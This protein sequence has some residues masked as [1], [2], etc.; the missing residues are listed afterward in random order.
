M[1]FIP[2]IVVL[3]LATVLPVAGQQKVQLPAADR[4][5]SLSVQPLYTVG[6]AEGEAW[7]S[8]A[9]VWQVAF[10]AQGR[11]YVLDSGNHRIHVFDGGG[12][13]MRSI[14]RR[15][16]G[17]GEFH[18]PIGLAITGA[19]ELVVNDAMRALQ[20]FSLN[21]TYKRSIEPSEKAG[22][23]TSQLYPHGTDGVFGETAPGLGSGMR[24]EG[25]PP[26][27]QPRT[28]AYLPFASE[29]RTL[30][31][32]PPAQSTEQR[33]STGPEQGFFA[34]VPVA[35]GPRLNWTVLPDRRGI[36]AASG[37]EYRITVVGDRGVQTRVIERAI[38]PRKVT[39]SDR[40]DHIKAAG[41][42]DAIVIT[43]PDAPAG[44]AE[45]ARQMQK[46]RLANM[47]FAEVMPVIQKLAADPTG[48]VW[49]QRSGNR[50]AGGG[51]IDLISPQ[52]NY[53]GTLTGQKMPSAFGPD[54]RVAYIEKDELG[55][56]RVVVKRIR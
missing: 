21:G 47:R 29:P 41:N 12:K 8:F 22:R 17:P 20:V 5:A 46:E 49:V 9:Q 56:Q 55:V 30:Y 43:Q 39:Q 52:G 19:D 54:G 16:S 38:S 28:I 2:L 36:A 45:L 6:V 33:T 34:H 32:A 51:P 23:V 48:R 15:G 7:E 25:A 42:M 4:A 40:E 11:L 53:L 14:G 1:R 35:F 18:M 26:P 31:V 27:V 3:L 10:D 50:T 37:V 44:T 13:F 24:Y